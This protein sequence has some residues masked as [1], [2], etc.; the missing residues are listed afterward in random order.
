MK[1]GSRPGDVAPRGV[2]VPS[3]R[4]HLP[5]RSVRGRAPDSRRPGARVAR[6]TGRR[7]HLARVGLGGRLGVTRWTTHVWSPPEEG[8]RPCGERPLGTRRED[9]VRSAQLLEVA[10]GACAGDAVGLR[11]GLAPVGFERLSRG[12]VTRGMEDKRF[13]FMEEATRFFHRSW[14]GYCIYRVELAAEEG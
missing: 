14:T 8:V 13:V 3:S 11:R 9:G 10:A 1:S 4:V 2:A 6:S 5:I 7:E 12:L